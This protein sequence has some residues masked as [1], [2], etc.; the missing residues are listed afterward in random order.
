MTSHMP[1][2]SIATILAAST[3]EGQCALEA[4]RQTWHR[5]RLAVLHSIWVASQVAQHASVASTGFS[6]AFTAP[7]TADQQASTQDRHCHG[8]P[9]LGEVQ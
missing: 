5:L 1:Q 6:S 4:L 3:A 2:A 9:R 7:C 8:S